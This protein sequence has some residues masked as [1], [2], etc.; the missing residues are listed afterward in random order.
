MTALQEMETVSTLHV[1][2]LRKTKRE[3]KL[4]PFFNQIN[5][6]SK[7]ILIF[8]IIISCKEAPTETINYYGTPSNITEINF[9][10]KEEEKVNLLEKMAD[11]ELKPLIGLPENEFIIKVDKVAEYQNRYYVLDKKKSNIWI[12]S[13][14][15]QYIAKV[16]KRGGGPEEYISANDYVIH[17]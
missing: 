1:H 3:L 14:E 13:T 9:E 15:G 4:T 2:L 12:F 11:I 10:V 6:K 16:G 5:M 8:F 17:K 7:H